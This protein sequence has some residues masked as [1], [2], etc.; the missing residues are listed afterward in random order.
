MVKS[1]IAMGVLSLSIVRLSLRGGWLAPPG[2]QGLRLERVP[3]VWIYPW[4]GV[5]LQAGRGMG[6]LGGECKGWGRRG[7]EGGTLPVSLV[8]RA[9]GSSV[10][11]EH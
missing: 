1:G 10:L 3:R 2:F 9:D 6:D 5:R 4:P 8:A 7:L 11:I